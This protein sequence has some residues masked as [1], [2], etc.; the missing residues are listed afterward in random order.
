MVQRVPGFTL[1]SGFST[2]RGFAGAAGNVVING[3]RPSNKSDSLATV[4]GRIPASR[5]RRIEL[6]SG[7]QFGSDYVGKA[8]VLNLVLND[9]GGLAGTAE[10]RLNREYT[11]RILPRGNANLIYRRGVHSFDASVNFSLNNMLSDDGFDRLTLLPGGTETEYREKRRVNTEPWTILAL[12]WSMDE[13]DDRSA[14]LTGNMS[15]DKWLLTDTSIVTGA[16]SRL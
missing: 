9:E 14:H 6:S 16:G 4:L 5:V 3:Q 12:G 7:N 1:E 15:F 11:G 2:V 10:V 8:Q 13:A